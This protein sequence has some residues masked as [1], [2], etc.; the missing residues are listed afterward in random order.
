MVKI[1]RVFNNKCSKK[2]LTLGEIKAMAPKTEAPKKDE[3]NA[4]EATATVTYP[5]EEEQ[6]VGRADFEV[7]FDNCEEKIMM[8]LFQ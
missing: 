2:Q 5:V 1:K 4:N 6:S 8:L 3:G 7:F